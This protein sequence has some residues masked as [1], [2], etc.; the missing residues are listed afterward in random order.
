[1]TTAA[2]TTTTLLTTM[3]ASTTVTDE[4]TMSIAT[5]ATTTSANAA[6]TT[7]S[8]PEMLDTHRWTILHAE[9]TYGHV[10][11]TREEFNLGFRQATGAIVRRLCADCIETHRE[12]YYKRKASPQTWDAYEGLLVTFKGENLHVQFDIYSSLEDALN[13]KNPWQDCMDMFTE[14][15]GFPLNCGPDQIVSPFAVPPQWTSLTLEGGQVNY[16]FD[17]YH[18]DFTDHSTNS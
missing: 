16:E 9:G 1:M 6:T 18:D 13:D 12:M 3:A 11:L 10:N 7:V 2:T 17:A 8:T 4:T 14:G 15:M 5:T